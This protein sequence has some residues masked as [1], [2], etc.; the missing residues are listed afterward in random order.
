MR[1]LEVEIRAEN[2]MGSSDI[3][4]VV[5]SFALEG[6][7]MTDREGLIVWHPEKLSVQVCP[8]SS[9]RNNFSHRKLRLIV[10]N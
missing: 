5:V 9:I 10:F 1:V 3:T 2:R 6:P 4:G 8:L 7:V